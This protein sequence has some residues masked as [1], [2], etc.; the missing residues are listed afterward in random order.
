ME[1]S[2][3]SLMNALGAIICGILIATEA[4]AEDTF[5]I[6][7]DELRSAVVFKKDLPNPTRVQ[8]SYFSVLIPKGWSIHSVQADDNYKANLSASPAPELEGQTTYL[9]LN[10]KRTPSGKSLE[11]RYSSLDKKRKQG[12]KLYFAIWQGQ[13][14][15]VHEYSRRL[16][17]NKEA[18]AWT[19]WTVANDEEILLI[20]A[21]PKK[22]V[23]QFEVQVKG[24]MQSTR[25]NNKATSARGR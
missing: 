8:N 9:S 20:A 19:A 23:A 21:I 13:R 2:C 4:S 14:W 7:D 22:L 24:I 5:V 11:Q 16:R 15:L 12:D 17:N 3:R 18:K 1:G 10:V 25:F 6:P